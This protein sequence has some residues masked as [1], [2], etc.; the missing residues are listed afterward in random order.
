MTW[1]VLQ[2]V[3]CELTCPIIA[4]FCV[5]PSGPMKIRTQH[6]LPKWPSVVTA[7]T[8]I[9]DRLDCENDLLGKFQRQ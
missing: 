4:T 7:A 3:F 6:H 1:R 9:V 2:C 5:R 8:V